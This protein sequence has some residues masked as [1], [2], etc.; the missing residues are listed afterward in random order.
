MSV[1]LGALQNISSQK[2]KYGDIS[3]SMEVP[4]SNYYNKLV[5]DQ[6]QQK[7]YLVN[8]AY[9]KLQDCI[10]SNSQ[11]DYQTAD[12]I[13]N[14][15]KNWA[16]DNEVTH[17]T[18]WFQPLTGKTSEKHDTFFK[19]DRDWNA[20]EE[21]EGQELIV[22]EPDGSS[23]PSGGL[24][25]TARARGYSIWDPTSNPF[26][27]VTRT[28][29][30]LCIP[31][32]LITYTGESLD[33]KSPLLRSIN[34]LNDAAVS[35]CKYFDE[36]INKVYPN[37]GWE[38]EY[39]VVDESLFNARPD[40]ILC[41]RTL[42]GNAS[43]RGQQLDD[44]YF[45]TIPERVHDFII[46]F[47]QESLKVGIPIKTRHNEVAPNQ[48]ECAPHFEHANISVDHNQLLMDMIDR[49]AKRH[50]LRVLLH[51]KP[52]AGLNGSGKH[53]N[54]SLA[55]NTGINLFDPGDN[56]RQNLRFLSFFINVIKA[57]HD[58]A[59]LLRASIANVGNEHRLGAN[60]APPAI[61]SVFTGKTMEKILNDFRDDVVGDNT[62]Y[63]DKDKLVLNYSKF[64]YIKRH[65][66]DRNRT[67]P[68]PFTGNKF[69][70]RA[71]GS[72]SNCATP[73]TILNLIV[74]D[75]LKKFKKDVDTLLESG[76]PQD[77]AIET[78][79]RNYYKE[80]EKIV[81]NGDNYSEEWVKEAEKRGLPNIKSTPEALEV[82]LKKESCDLFTSNG[83]FTKEEVQAR[84][85]V[86][87][88]EYIH[89]LDIEAVLIEEIANTQI[90]PAVVKYQNEIL[91]NVERMKRIGLNIESENHKNKLI[92]I[93][94]HLEIML[95]S[96]NSMEDERKI[97]KSL[98]TEG[99]KA[100]HYFYKVKPFFE[101]I[102]N[103]ADR[104][105][106]LVDDRYWPLP[107]YREL[108]FMH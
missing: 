29:R 31:A 87:I 81:F 10:Q 1:R 88:E 58:N 21:F 9:E 8:E 36:N 41:G 73:N 68:F 102:R 33:L 18:H 12:L 106:L 55:T 108:L 60:E 14:G 48:F 70:F 105:E 77:E 19:F 82:Y 59:E 91:D 32:T 74:A 11:L 26:I 6:A 94:E 107:K 80:T 5:F 90:I 71:A 45:A 38:Q 46:D 67:S 27:R 34:I 93:S 85:N 2:K 97:A 61:I 16:I 43:A 72:S 24:R 57:V 96:L 56:P 7:K 103:H 78:T 101:I 47:E 25:D 20:I 53:N 84:Y 3:S 75:Q 52:F 79:L 99:E 51:E 62:E 64:P 49:V 95:Q 35:V 66:A 44:H 37:L 13:A 39:F 17:Y 69:E 42:F 15:L 92:Q 30:T 4:V 76:T 65:T 104:L 23:F 83:L 98:D 63:A 22:Q 50:G 28:G 40:L 54:W 86:F 89:K 100:R